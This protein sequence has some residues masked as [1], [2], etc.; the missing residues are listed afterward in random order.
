MDVAICTVSVIAVLGSLCL[1]GYVVFRLC[2]QLDEQRGSHAAGLEVLARSL[3]TLSLR[4][5]T[6][7][8]E[9]NAQ[10]GIVGTQR[11]EG[12]PPESEPLAS[13]GGNGRYRP[14]PVPQGMEEEDEMPADRARFT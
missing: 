1:A 6:L 5:P 7:L 10:G 9:R 12:A 3:S 11:I 14:V 4:R 13:A 2:R 8:I